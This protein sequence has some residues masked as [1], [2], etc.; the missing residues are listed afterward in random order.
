MSDSET[1]GGSA[2]EAPKP[3]EIDPAQSAPE[4]Q[5]AP[6]ISSLMGVLFSPKTTFQ[7]IV[8]RPSWTGALV[9]YLVAVALAGLVYSLNV[10]WEAMYRGE[11]ESSL[12]WRMATAALSEDQLEE[13]ERAALSNIR[14]TGPGGMTLLTT[15]QGVVY[16]TIA[17]HFMA[18]IFATLFYLMGSLSDLKLGRVYLDALLCLL[19][20]LV[21]TFGSGAVSAVFSEDARSALPYQAGLNAVFFIVYFW[22][23]R[24]SVERQPPFKRFM[25]SYAHAMIVPAVAALLSIVVVL[26][27]KDPITVGWGEV[28]Q[29]NLG[30]LFAVE[31][32]GPL[33]TLL[34][35]LEIFRLWELVIVAIGFAAATRQSLGTSVAITFLPWGFV[36]MARI[37]LAAVFGG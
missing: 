18:I 30:A 31:G 27:H 26:L 6:L 32:S 10:D 13:M 29:S 33:A 14:S 21:L 3:A 16:G 24:R 11:L 4:E 19:V 23:F 8:A 28:L 7:M 12:G 20:I 1:T 35:A 34:S 36:T 5:G 17:I 25:A 9:V 15:L 37:A 22:L 2:S